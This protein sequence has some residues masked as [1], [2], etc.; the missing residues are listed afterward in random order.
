M[1]VDLASPSLKSMKYRVVRSL[2]VGA[3]STILLIAET[4][5]G[6]QF[7]LKVVKKQQASD[8]IYVDQAKT[9]YEVAQRINHPNLLKVY[10]LRLGRTGSRRR[11]SSC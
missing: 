9:E 8:Q 11:V 2:G 7:A 10:D 3:G 6:R 4:E 1:S 5:G